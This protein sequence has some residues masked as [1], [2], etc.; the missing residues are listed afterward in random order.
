MNRLRRLGACA[1]LLL[2]SISPAA[3]QDAPA[4][5][6]AALRA[7]IQ[8]LRNR[9]L[10]D[11]VR[12]S[13][14]DGVLATLTYDPRV[15]QLDRGQPG[16]TPTPASVN[17]PP[18]PFA[19]YRAS[20]VEPYRIAVGKRRLQAILP[21]LRT[22][23]QQTGVSGPLM[24]AIYGQETGYGSVTGNFDLLRSLATL[25][26]DGRRRPLFAGEYLAALKLL[27]RGIVPRER[28][29]GSW[30]GA[31]G[32]PQ[33]LP[34]VYFRLAADGDGDGRKDIWSSEPDALA[35]IAAYLRDAGWKP[36]VQWGVPV[37]VAPGLDRT[38]IRPLAVSADCPR[39][40]AQHSRW[41]TMAEWRALG[42]QPVAP[43]APADRELAALIEPDGPGATAYL[44]TTNYRSILGYN[45]SNHYALSVGLLADA[46]QE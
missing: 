23:E 26:F 19:P 28:L 38:A 29:K 9:A 18:T 5:Q 10:A 40:F 16:G 33:F 27:D 46:V 15:V 34:S 31:T 12:G 4:G 43:R 36:G 13:T 45:C 25:A 41:L 6:D 32:Y 3:A 39:V 35:S 22:I 44:L 17:R 11:G 14:F 1:A 42:V 37:R 30:A 8:T 2:G 21:R 24:L 7:Y 20:H